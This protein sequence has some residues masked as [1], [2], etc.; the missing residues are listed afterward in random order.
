VHFDSPSQWLFSALSVEALGAFEL[1]DG[2]LLHPEGFVVVLR[3]LHCWL[4]FV[5]HFETHSWLTVLMP[6]VVAHVLSS[7]LTWL[8][9][10]FPVLVH[11]LQAVVREESVAYVLAAQFLQCRLPPW[12]WYLPG[13]HCV[14]FF[15]P[16]VGCSS[17][18]ALPFLPVGQSLQPF[19]PS[20]F[21]Y[22]P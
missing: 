22:S 8:E 12:F 13:T 5:A 2:E 9:L 15:V 17:A 3:P 11:G 7:F 20:W 1:V 6:A 4:L 14:H 10:Q 18:F 21:W 16:D 19:W